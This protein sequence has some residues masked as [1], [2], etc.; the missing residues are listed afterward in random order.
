VALRCT[1]QKGRMYS[2]TF[3]IDMWGARPARSAQHVLRKAQH[4]RARMCAGVRAKLHFAQRVPFC[5]LRMIVSGVSVRVYDD[6]GH[7]RSKKEARHIA[8]QVHI[9]CLCGCACELPYRNTP[10]MLA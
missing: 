3:G 6:K 1:D 9:V 2:P 5:G 8:M 7:K 10:S 4:G